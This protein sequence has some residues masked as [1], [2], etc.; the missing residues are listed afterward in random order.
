[1]LPWH[2]PFDHLFVVLYTVFLFFALQ[3]E[4]DSA[5]KQQR[6]TDAMEAAANEFT[7]QLQRKLDD[8]AFVQQS[9]IVEV[10]DAAG[11]NCVRACSA[12]PRNDCRAS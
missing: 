12:W 3:F 6:A 1:M 2:S 7:T 11:E 9:S 10:T 8:L 4:G 5:D